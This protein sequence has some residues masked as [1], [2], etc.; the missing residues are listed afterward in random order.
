[1]EGGILNVLE[2]FL[3]LRLSGDSPGEN[4]ATVATTML[5]KKII[6]IQ[7]HLRVNFVNY[8]ALQF[9]TEQVKDFLKQNKVMVVVDEAHRIKNSEGVWV[10]LL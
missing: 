8:S 3:L 4:G 7:V 1:M 9:I 10:R 5:E 2:D 6:F